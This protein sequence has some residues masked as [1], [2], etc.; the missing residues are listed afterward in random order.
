MKSI[1]T[2]SILLLLSQFL[3]AKEKFT[4]TTKL[5]TPKGEL[6]SVELYNN[7]RS[8]LYEK[9]F[10]QALPNGKYVFVSTQGFETVKNA[11]PSRRSAV[12]R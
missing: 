10:W 9:I 8:L 11:V 12:H 6:A 5:Y 1:K 2:L 4:D 7:L 3:L